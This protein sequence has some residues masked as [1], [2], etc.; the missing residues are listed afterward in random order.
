M[1]RVAT[2]A[3]YRGM[4]EKA[5]LLFYPLAGDPVKLSEYMVESG[6]RI[7]PDSL[8]REVGREEGM[9][10]GEDGLIWKSGRIDHSPSSPPPPSHP[11]FE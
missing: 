10:G 5:G 1:V 6:G 9:V 8:D 3:C 4:V 11:I 7:M 2:H